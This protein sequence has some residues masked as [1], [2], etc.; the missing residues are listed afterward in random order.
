MTSLPSLT[1]ATHALNLTP[2]G[3][4]SGSHAKVYIGA[5]PRFASETRQVAGC[6][7]RGKIAF[8]EESAASA[9][10]YFLFI[11][12]TFLKSKE[13]LL[14][15][16][17]KLSD[18][19]FRQRIFPVIMDKTVSIFGAGD[20]QKYVQYWEGMPS[21]SEVD[22]VKQNIAPLIRILRDTLMPPLDQ[23]LQGDLAQVTDAI[24]KRSHL[25]DMGHFFFLPAAQ[26]QVMRKAAQDK[27]SSLFKGQT[28]VSISGEK[29]MG[30]TT[31]AVEYAKQQ[32]QSTYP[33]GIFWLDATDE[34]TL[35]ESYRQMAVQL[36]I[37]PDQVKRKLSFKKDFLLIYDNV[38]ERSLVSTFFSG[39][40]LIISPNLP[41]SDVVLG[42]FTTEEANRYI[43]EQL[44]VSSSELCHVL[45]NH[46]AKLAEAIAYI[47]RLK[48]SAAT[49]VEAYTN[50]RE[51]LLKKQQAK[52]STKTSSPT[53]LSNLDLSPQTLQS[54]LQLSLSDILKAFIAQNIQVFIS[55]N[56]GATKEVDQIG[57][58]F[59]EMGTKLLRDTDEARNFESLRNFM[60]KVIKDADYTISIVSL[61]YLQSFNCIFEVITIM[62]DPYW[63]HRLFPLVIEGTDLS[64]K[65]IHSYVTYW[66]EEAE[67][68]ERIGANP[69]EVAIAREG[70][71]KI[72]PF[73][74]FVKQLQPASIETELHTQFQRPLA[75]MLARQ[76][77]LEKKGVYRQGIFHLPGR[78]K[79]FVGR[80]TELALLEKS[81][82][83]GNSSAI[84]NTGMG[85]VGKSQLAYEYAYR[86]E[87]E[88]KMIYS[89]RSEQEATIKADLRA[90]GLE[91][92][93]AE[94]F[95]KD[96]IVIS[97]MKNTL[98]K[99]KGW[100]LIFDNAEDPELLRSILPQGGHI[101]ITSRNPNWEKSV[102][103]DVFS[104][105][106]ALKYLQKISGISD[107]QEEFNLLAEELGY[108]PLALTQAGAYIRRQQMDVATYRAAF[109]AGEKQLLSQKEKGYPGSVATAWL[110]SMEKIKQ[111]DPN[112][113]QLL[114]ICSYLAP[115]KI[116]DE[117]LEA[118]LKEKA[119]TTGLDFQNAL[120]V[121]ES[122]S[123]IEQKVEEKDGFHKK[124]I[125]VHRLIQT[126][127]RDECEPEAN[128]AIELGIGVMK[129]Q[130]QGKSGT[131]EKREAGGI[132]VLHAQSLIGHA[133]KQGIVNESAGH[134][135]LNT[136]FF[137]SDTGNLKEAKKYHEKAL[138]IHIACL[139]AESMQTADSY[140]SLGTVA[141]AQGDL[142]EAKKYFQ[143][144]IDIYFTH[145]DTDVV[146]AG[147]GLALANIN[148]GAVFESLNDFK[149]AKECLE[150]AIKFFNLIEVENST[151][152]A[153]CH[154]NLG[155]ILLVQ[156]ELE[157]AKEH[158]EKALEINTVCL[159]TENH[160]GIA[161]IYVNLANVLREKER[162]EEEEA[163]EHFEKA[164]EIFRTC[165]GTENHPSVAVCYHN[166]GNVLRDQ[167][168][169]EEAKKLYE[170]SLEIRVNCLGED[171]TD[172]AQSYC[173]IGNVLKGQ[174][175]FDAAKLLMEKAASHLISSYGTE[176]HLDLGWIYNNLGSVLKDQGDLAGAKK[177]YE[178][179]LKIRINCLGTKNHR[180]IATTYVNL[181]DVLKGQKFFAEAKA[182]Y[183][184]ALEI[185]IACLGRNHIDVADCYDNIGLALLLQSDFSG[186]KT[187]YENALEIYTDCLGTNHASVAATY[188][189]IGTALKAQGHLV[190]A[191]K[192]Y[193]NALEFYIIYR[194]ES[195]VKAAKIYKNLGDVLKAQEDYS[196]AK[197][198]YKNA[199][200]VY[201]ACRGEN[202]EDVADSYVNIGG[203]L[204][205]QGDFVG[206]KTAYE[207][208]LK[209]YV[210]CL[211]KN[212]ETVANTYYKFGNMLKAQED[213]SGAK[214]AYENA[215]EVY[216]A[217]RGENHEDVADS[218]KK[219]G[220]VLQA[221]G[222]LE[223]AKT[224]YE[225]E[226]KVRIV[227]VGTDN[228]KVAESYVR[229]ADVCLLLKQLERARDCYTEAKQIYQQSD[230]DTYNAYF[231][232]KISECL[233]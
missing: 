204:K 168:K 96:D 64:E 159:G 220:D 11:T 182:A 107:Q 78:N 15:L 101:L 93:I 161:L 45:E 79:E 51:N 221:Q 118:W 5:E 76:E 164:L 65:A 203:L 172:V 42:A 19:E 111:E 84:T 25:L 104:K 28:V 30:K 186:A 43:T 87:T 3:Q 201:I 22:T 124:T 88:Y 61:K 73:L 71:E 97:T 180:D 6:L 158:F 2:Y 68:L 157:A 33:S 119:H 106:E 227:C 13:H 231:D 100:L 120:G 8:Q 55:Y 67:R 114:N 146:E 160:T 17:S 141:K 12:D 110:L 50:D 14:P 102:P 70:A 31:L 219:I 209:M 137:L 166:I 81:L 205:A 75:I 47:K 44:G 24:N 153:A 127:T 224:A 206:A 26:A 215:L 52:A 133:E 193:E 128:Q 174:G 223:E 199:L 62:K 90:L 226:L 188:S 60:I 139:G 194:K 38:T 32:S 80:E 148:M 48:I 207:T 177:H 181:G 113:L 10:H 175:K 21:D 187:I 77:K 140:N 145:Q 134:V 138:Q 53:L 85:G 197:E 35:E 162:P 92:G 169:L 108:L 179:A 189:N 83:N 121:L 98:E 196:G 117:F 192:S 94:D 173:S 41:R 214:E 151:A 150:K 95:L 36:G 217:C 152:V 126:V 112:A 49:Y 191:K 170:K 176:D 178:K 198:A 116:P 18:P 99:R 147:I 212:H 163:K 142:K 149:G 40:T 136:G 54:Y 222:N 23:L 123:L 218:Y 125:F 144:V 167:G 103:V 4:G 208:A 89:I 7:Q 185:R 16:I 1:H 165:L 190:E 132:L 225:N 154:T 216:I 228:I 56:W 66:K 82:K 135:A 27:L 37:N 195:D 9:T 210:E 183:E 105:E 129:Q 39:H 233:A 74:E 115:D 211:G 200:E 109:K 34:N 91:M 131:K 184:T 229:V 63:K 213:Y 156:G 58:L 20:E 130:F 29:G 143:R 155:N 69:T 122:Y 46:P 59:E 57:T 86:H 171:H 202:H 72:A 230:G 232:D